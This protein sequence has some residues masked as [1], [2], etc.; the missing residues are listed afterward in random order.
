MLKK[1][2]NAQVSLEALA[3]ISIMLGIFAT[4]LVLYTN[5]GFVAQQAVRTFEEAKDC[6][7]IAVAINEM[8]K[9]KGTAH[10]IVS[11]TSNFR[12]KNGAIAFGNQ[13]CRYYGYVKND[14]TER[15]FNAGKYVLAKTVEGVEF[16]AA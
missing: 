1:A 14:S 2:D 12:L 4:V 10:V 16:Y 8:S 13:L 15:A 9:S 5:L 11:A 3:S 7:K 6:E